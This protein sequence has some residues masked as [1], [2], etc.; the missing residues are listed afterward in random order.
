MRRRAPMKQKGSGEGGERAGDEGLKMKERAWVGI[1]RGLLAGRSLRCSGDGG[2]RWGSG[3]R[4]RPP[5]WR[6]V[7][8]PGTGLEKRK[9]TRGTAG[10]RNGLF[11]PD[12]SLK[13]TVRA[14]GLKVSPG[15][16]GFGDGFRE[17]GYTDVY[18]KPLKDG[19]GPDAMR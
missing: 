19:P 3:E 11:L 16:C 15:R 2:R 8:N 13:E 1:A 4:R 12:L 5:V 6:E 18:G 14:R 9:D 10:R 17:G 7:R